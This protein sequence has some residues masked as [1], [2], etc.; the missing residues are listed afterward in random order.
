MPG[1]FFDSSALAKHYHVEVGMAPESHYPY[2]PAQTGRAVSRS[3]VSNISQTLT[4]FSSTRYAR[5]FPSALGTVRL[6]LGQVR[7]MP[8]DY[9]EQ[10]GIFDVPEGVVGLVFG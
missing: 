10:F 4:R 1:Y 6:A 2:Q 7:S 8:F 9:L 3:R 5:D